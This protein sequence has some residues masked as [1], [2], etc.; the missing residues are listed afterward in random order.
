M[1]GAN[2]HLTGHQQASQDRRLLILIHPHTFSYITRTASTGTC[3]KLDAVSLKHITP[4]HWKIHVISW[5]K[6]KI[7]PMIYW[8]YLE[9]RVEMSESN[10][11]NSPENAVL[12]QSKLVRNLD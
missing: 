3:L 4:I 6:S 2:L 7:Q 1:V 9:L 12:M 10:M 8:D 5:S 11:V